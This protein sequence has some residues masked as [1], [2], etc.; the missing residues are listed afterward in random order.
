MSEYLSEQKV[1]CQTFVYVD[2]SLLEAIENRA[3]SSP[4]GRGK[5]SLR[6]TG[7][8]SP[9]EAW[10]YEMLPTLLIVTWA[11]IAQAGD[12]QVILEKFQSI[13]PQDKPLAICE[14]DWAATLT[15]AKARA[16]RE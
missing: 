11:A 5:Q 10:K 12:V 3:A 9:T 7:K 16:A 8:L 1:H 14:F 13:Q 2:P 15:D 6:R 4:P